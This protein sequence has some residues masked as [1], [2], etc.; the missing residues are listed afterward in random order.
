MG[1]IRAVF[2]LVWFA[3]VICP[4]PVA[5]YSIVIDAYLRANNLITM[6]ER[7]G[8]F[9]DFQKK[10][11]AFIQDEFSR[12]LGSSL[13][14]NEKEALLNGYIMKLKQ[15]EIDQGVLD[16]TKF[17]P[18]HHFFEVLDKINDSELFQIIQK[19]PKGGVLHAHDTALCNLD[20]IVQLTYW[21]HLWQTTDPESQRPRFKFSRNKPVTADN[22]EWQLVKTVRE[23][24]GQGAYDSEL[25][26]LVS[27]YN[28]NPV[29]E[30]RDVNAMWVK[31]MEIFAMSDGLLMYKDAW[32][33]YF[34]QALKEFSADQVSYLEVRSTLPKVSCDY[35]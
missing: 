9:E 30:A 29:T 11:D 27:L 7:S 13:V 22:L 31:F 2:C 3:V 34:L 17:I 16:P 4:P 5:P 1:P 35:I 20:F 23:A 10:R 33:A 15:H 18:A 21:D 25:R 26:K 14:L 12:G 32:E 24:R 28:E 6:D 8:K 19:M